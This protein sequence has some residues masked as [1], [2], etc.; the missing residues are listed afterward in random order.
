MLWELEWWVAVLT[1]VKQRWEKWALCGS[2]FLSLTLQILLICTGNRRKYIHSACLRGFI[3]LAYLMANPVVFSAFSIIMDMTMEENSKILDGEINRD[4]TVDT[5]LYAFWSPFLLLHLGGPDTF[6]AYALEDNQLWL[7]ELFHLVTRAGVTVFIFLLVWPKPQLFILTMVMILVGLVKYSERVYALWTASSEQFRNSIPDRPPNYSKIMEQQKLMEAEGYTVIPLEVIEVHDVEN[8]VDGA[9]LSSPEGILDPEQLYK[10]KQGELLAAGG[11]INIFQRLFA[12]LPLSFEDKRTGQSVLKDRNPLSAL[13]IIEI[14]LGIMYDLLYTKATAIYSNWG[15]ARRIVGLFLT[16]IVLAIL[17]QV[18]RQPYTKADIWTSLTLLA[19]AIFLEIYALTVLLF[20]DRTACWLIKQKKFAILDLIN[21]LQPLTKRRRWSNHMAQF[22]LLSFAFKEK[23]HPYHRLLEFLHIDEM[24]EKPR[25][26][27]HK[28]VTDDIKYRIVSYIREMQFPSTAQGSREVNLSERIKH[29][30][31]TMELEFHQIIL[32]WHIAT[33]LLYG[34]K[35]KRDLHEQAKPGKYLSRYMLYI[36][37]MHPEMLPT[38]NG[39]IKFRETYIEAM[40]FF[41]GPKPI[42]AGGDT[43]GH[44]PSL[45]D[46]DGI[47]GYRKYVM[48]CAGFCAS[49][50]QHIKKREKRKLDMTSAYDQLQKQ[51]NT[52]L[53]LT[54]TR[55]EKSKYVLFQGCRLASQLCSESSNDLLG[56]VVSNMWVRILC[57][58]AIKC[59]PS[60]H[61]Q[62]LRRG[63]ELLTH[64]WFMMAHFGL[65]D[66][67]Q[68]PPAPVVV[69]LVMH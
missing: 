43:D 41:D 50:W 49:A 60:Y 26:I 14:E 62:Q 29:L 5:M 63:G 56:D 65:T 39:G 46:E 66:H 12:D 57:D 11:L 32:I 15:F 9:D 19:A 21:W 1:Y 28:K 27:H 55:G 10:R 52:K 34:L 20:S 64:A 25:Y 22:S 16:C 7:R 54:V 3:W 51:V 13:T 24:V 48:K 58:A 30:Q 37:V 67:F 18:D 68:I 2:I 31:W 45:G 42:E 8:S 33:E 38:G 4:T 6:T 44:A 17:S 53:N 23:H 47:Q 35:N 36:L 40:K 59:K 61:A 69:E